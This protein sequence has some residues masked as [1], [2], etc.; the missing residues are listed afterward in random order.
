MK[1]LLIEDN[2]EISDNISK[3]L[4][5]K[6]PEYKIIQAFDGEEAV[7]KFLLEDFDFILLDLMLPKID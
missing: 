2:I 6:N 4:K 3:I 1:I 7:K 5:F